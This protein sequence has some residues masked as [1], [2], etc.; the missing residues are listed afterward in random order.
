[1]P[2]IPA[3]RPATFLSLLISPLIV[4]RKLA[5]KFKCHGV[6]KLWRYCVTDHLSETLA[7]RVS[8]VKEVRQKLDA[9]CLP[10]GKG[11]RQLRMDEASLSRRV[12]AAGDRRG[13][14][15]PVQTTIHRPV[16]VIF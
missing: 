10:R 15:I 12:E 4:N 8:P 11:P 14:F 9:S 7:I 6:C 3:K 1:M 16:R 5:Q 2:P 13:G